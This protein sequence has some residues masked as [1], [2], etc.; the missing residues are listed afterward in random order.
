MKNQS[1]REAIRFHMRL[2]LF[3]IGICILVSAECPAQG[4]SWSV[5]QLGAITLPP[6]P[7]ATS[8]WRTDLCTGVAVD[9]DGN[10]YCSGYTCG[11]LGE[12]NATRQNLP[13]L[14]CNN[15]DAFVMKVGPK[16]NILWI[17]QLGKVTK[18]PNVAPALWSQANQGN[19]FCT[20]VAVG[21]EGY[22]Y[23][24]GYTDG[25]ISEANA[26]GYDAMVL[27]LR[28][29]D[30][31]LEWATQ[32]GQSTAVPGVNPALAGANTSK[33][34][35]EF[36][37]GIAVDRFGN[38]YCAGYTTGFFREQVGGA[39]DLFLMRLNPGGTVEWVTQ[40]GQQTRAPGAGP[41]LVNQG[42]EQCMGATVDFDSW[43]GKQFVYCAGYTLGALGEPNRNPSGSSGDAFVLK[44]NAADGQFLLQP[45]NETWLVQLGAQTRVPGAP[46]HANLSDDQCN[47][48]FVDSRRN[49]YC[50]GHTN[51]YL[52]EE[53]AGG[54]D[55]FALK[56]DQFGQIEWA[57]QF[58]NVSRVPNAPA[59]P[60]WHWDRFKG[61]AV[62]KQGNVYCAGQ[63]YGPFAEPN[64]VP[65]NFSSDLLVVRL[66]KFGVPVWGKQLGA[67]SR[68]PITPGTNLNFI[69]TQNIGQ[70]D[71]CNS[72]AIAPNGDVVCGGETDR[73]ISEQNGAV[74][75]L[76]PSPGDGSG[77]DAV[78]IRLN[79]RTGDFAQPVQTN[80]K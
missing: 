25:V 76:L 80:K 18:A 16:G 73:F 27:K 26:G 64:A 34:G 28:Q 77:Q 19:D 78:L 69:G 29:A 62:D 50:A 44:L 55:A 49:V 17:T 68:A 20:S 74:R 39:G 37:N 35:S 41:I 61:V 66:N 9:K 30:G 75:H 22:V 42:F 48:I 51:G 23:C 5:L 6:N 56:V 67:N 58:G 8:N 32:L 4:Q 46:V 14:A 40:L 13:P 15:V 71:L 21:G 53:N 24:G 45:A 31:G 3:W 54:S 12:G 38:I 1:N 11:D 63:T 59:W 79:G 10:T 36:C 60:N 57:R 33:Q 52:A 70:S 72:V 65:T 2:L 7:P 47:G 43:G